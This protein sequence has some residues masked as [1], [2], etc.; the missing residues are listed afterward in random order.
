M[1]SSPARSAADATIH[2]EPNASKY[3]HEHAS[4]SLRSKA[5][6]YLI[7]AVRRCIRRCLRP[8]MMSRIHRGVLP[9][10][11]IIVFDATWDKLSA[12][13]LSGIVA[14]LFGV[15]WAIGTVGGPTFLSGSP[16]PSGR[17]NSDRGSPA[18]GR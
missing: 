10:L 15:A 1:Q 8:S 2:T 16:W 18:P 12:R 4:R 17:R 11:T 5:A 14:D 13:L 6:G 3:P 7:L 9:R